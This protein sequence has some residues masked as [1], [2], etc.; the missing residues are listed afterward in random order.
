M[1]MEDSQLLIECTNRIGQMF[2]QG[3]PQERHQAITWLATNGFILYD[4]ET[5]HAHVD[6]SLSIGSK[7]RSQGY[8]CIGPFEQDDIATFLAVA[9]AQEFSVKQTPQHLLQRKLDR[10]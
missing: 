9:S 4:Q 2:V 8:A 10:T 1:Q 5:H 3:S 7:D 6:N